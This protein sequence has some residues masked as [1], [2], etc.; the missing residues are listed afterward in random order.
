MKY[1]IVFATMELA[2]LIFA[3][4]HKGRDRYAL[5]ADKSA[6]MAA[7]EAKIQTF[8]YIEMLHGQ[9]LLKYRDLVPQ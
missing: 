6:L 7:A 8:F 2:V 3:A 4:L 9:M 1:E 5:K